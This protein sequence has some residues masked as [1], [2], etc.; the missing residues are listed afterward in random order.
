LECVPLFED[1]VSINS[2][3]AFHIPNSKFLISESHPK[4]ATDLK[5]TDLEIRHARQIDFRASVANER[6]DAVAPRQQ[7]V[8]IELEI[9]PDTGFALA[10][11][12][13][14]RCL[15]SGWHRHRDDFLL[16]A[17]D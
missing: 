17:E 4:A 10:A 9:Y 3:R 14:I 1:P 15:R 6:A 13:R 7:V 12:A 16:D 11:H 5:T 2:G 8:A